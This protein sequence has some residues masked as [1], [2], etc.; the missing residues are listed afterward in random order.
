MVTIK[1]LFFFWKMNDNP[2]YPCP[3]SINLKKSRFC[4][5]KTHLKLSSSEAIYSQ[6]HSEEEMGFT[7][8]QHDHQI[9]I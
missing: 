7:Q 5:I 3:K 2:H 6:H 4:I 8:G 1:L 9:F